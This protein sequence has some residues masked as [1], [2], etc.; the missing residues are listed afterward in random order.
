MYSPYYNGVGMMP[1]PPPP[2]PPLHCITEYTQ[3]DDPD[4]PIH[5]SALH[6]QLAPPETQCYALKSGT[7]LK[8]GVSKVEDIEW[9]KEAFD[10]LVLKESIKSMLLGLVQRHKKDKNEVL[11]DL[12]PSKG[13]VR[14][15]G[16]FDQWSVFNFRLGTSNPSTWATWCW[17]DSNCGDHCRIHSKA[18][19]SN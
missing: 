11:S 10:Q 18:I 14:V 9:A 5:F 13:K 16:N 15:I 1:S 3:F 17:Q 19:V 4:D 12:I 7:W 2:P 6:A 8:I